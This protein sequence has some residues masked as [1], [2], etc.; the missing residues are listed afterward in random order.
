M[1]QLLRIE[2]IRGVV[3]DKGGKSYQCLQ[4]PLNVGIHNIAGGF[5]SG[6]QRMG[7]FFVLHLRAIAGKN[8][9]GNGERDTNSGDQRKSHHDLAMNMFGHGQRTLPGRAPPASVRGCI[10]KKSTVFYTV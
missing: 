9:E 8:I 7:C 3:A 10:V 2:P 1:K 5:R 6:L 4:I